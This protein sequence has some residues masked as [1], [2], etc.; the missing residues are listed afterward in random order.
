M[1]IKIMKVANY[2]AI[3]ITGKSRIGLPELAQKQI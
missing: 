2:L 1:H 3:A